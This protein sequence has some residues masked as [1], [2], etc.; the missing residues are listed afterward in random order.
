[1]TGFRKYLMLCA[2]ALLLPSCADRAWVGVVDGEYDDSED[3]FPVP[4][5]VGVGDPSSTKGTGAVDADEGHPFMDVNL[6]VYAFNSTTRAPFTAKA[7]SD[8]KSC[9]I[10]G[11]LDYPFSNEGRKAFFNG[12][13]IYVD[14]PDASSLTYYPVGN[15]DA[16]DFYAYFTD[17]YQPSRVMRSAD[18]IEIP[19]EIDG[20]RDIMSG[21]AVLSNEALPDYFSETEKHLLKQR[22]FSAYTARR[23]VNPV[24]NFRHH[25]TRLRFE[26]YPTSEESHK[27]VINS[28]GVK[29]RY[30]GNFTAVAR[31][32]EDEGIDFSSSSYKWLYLPE[33]DGSSLKRDTY[34]TLEGANLNLPLYERQ[35]VQVG[36]TILVAP[37][38]DYE[39]EVELFDYR[40]GGHSGKS[41]ID[42]SGDFLPGHQYVVRI[43]VYGLLEPQV[44]VQLEPWGTGGHIIIDNEDNFTPRN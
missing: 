23:G 22:A 1:M 17:D 5:L 6:Y 31:S 3:A 32:E 20:A 28:I 18:R 43:A 13:D 8:S 14:W 33:A 24:L 15:T 4:V 42:I 11:S 36:G 16:Y 40:G 37:D 34:H 21:R 12:S 38:S 19:V 25:L 41:A 10:D 9:L 7:A 27:V 29:S 35:A 2:A 30:S 39:A 44:T 26:I